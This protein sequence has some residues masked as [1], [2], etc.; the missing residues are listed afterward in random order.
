MGEP[1]AELK[2]H[3][4]Y[5]GG[6]LEQAKELMRRRHL[7]AAE[8]AQEIGYSQS[9]VSRYLSGQLDNPEKVETAIAAFVARQGRFATGAKFAWTALAQAIVQKCEYALKYRKIIPVY[10][11]AGHGKTTAVLEFLLREQRNGKTP[12]IFITCNDGLTARELAEEILLELNISPQGSRRA[13]LRRIVAELKRRPH[14]ILIDDAAYL[15][16]RA[17]QDLR[18]LNDQAGCGI[19]LVGTESL[20]RRW[21]DAVGRLGEDLEQLQSRLGMEAQTLRPL[22]K[23]DIE[24]IAKTKEPG[25]NAQCLEIVARR[26]T[27]R[28]VEHLLDRAD[29]LRGLNPREPYIELLKQAEREVFRA[30]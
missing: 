29:Y 24:K 27:G 8:F 9:L 7:S 6:L 4:E 26:K 5:D 3:K 20:M 12:Y 13:L 28:E 18:F 23:M 11:S 2:L 25:L 14:I 22:S 30:A 15:K 16:E 1:A 21:I 10:I 19:V 17:L